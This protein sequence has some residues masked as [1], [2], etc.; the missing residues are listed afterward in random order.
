MSNVLTI[1]DSF[2][3]IR[4]WAETY[5]HGIILRPPASP[6]ALENFQDKSGLSLPEDLR[7]LLLMADGES[8]NSVGMIGN[9]RL[10]PIAEIQAVWGLLSKTDEKGAFSGLK[11]KSSPYISPNWWHSGWIPIVSSDTG[12]Y[13]CL[14]TYPPD[15]KRFSQV[16]LFMQSQ[17]ERYLIAAGLDV[18]LDRIWHDL[19][20]DRYQFD[21]EE[22]FHGEAFMWSSLEGKHYFDDIDGTLV[23]NHANHT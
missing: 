7:K 5:T 17:P 9:W 21:R 12:D 10:M 15:P 1:S 19:D 3:K 2:E 22:G 14:D 6:E 4:T 11:P 23:V 8:R 18:W 13:F 20:S 16:I